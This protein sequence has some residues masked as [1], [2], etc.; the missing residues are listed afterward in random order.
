MTPP[1][2][3]GSSS[4]IFDSLLYIYNIVCYFTGKVFCDS[5]DTATLLG[6]VKRQ[7]MFTPVVELKDMADF[8]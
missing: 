4:V 3:D 6:L 5:P 7:S 1:S 8:K 2:H